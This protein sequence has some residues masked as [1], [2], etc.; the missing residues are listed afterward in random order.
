MTIEKPGRALKRGPSLT[1]TVMID[2]YRGS[3]RVRK[4]PRKRGTTVSAKTKEQMEWFRQ[5]NLLAKYAAPV[6]QKTALKATENS[7]LLP[8]DIQLMAMAGRIFMI[9]LDD[10]RTI[11]PMA[12]RRDVSASLD[13]LGQQPGDIL[14]RGPEFWS[15]VP[16]AQAGYVLTSGGP[17]Q[18]PAWAPPGGSTGLPAM[19]GFFWDNPTF[20]TATVATKG[21]LWVPWQATTI[22]GLSALIGGGEAGAIFKFQVAEVN[23]TSGQIEIIQVLAE[24]DT[25]TLPNDVTNIMTQRFTNPVQLLENVP[26]YLAV[27]RTDA[28]TSGE[29]RAAFTNDGNETITIGGEQPPGTYSFAAIDLAP[30]QISN[31][32][33]TAIYTVWP[34]A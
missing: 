24:S 28:G 4:W 34:Y 20:S 18:A 26:Y 12:A 3:P 15:P 8:R 21:R 13:V 14:F 19:R 17:G 31:I 16:Q 10:G 33:G 5:A 6:E 29:C 27:T 22:Q 7:P 25:F 11:Y 32:P 2:T 23:Q 1:G 30:G 9:E